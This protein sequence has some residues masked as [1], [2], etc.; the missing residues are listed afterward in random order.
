MLYLGLQY[1]KYPCLLC[2]RA[3]RVS[4]IET[5]VTRRR[6]GKRSKDISCPC[7]LKLMD[8]P[9][10]LVSKTVPA[11][12]FKFPCI[13]LR[14]NA[15]FSCSLLKEGIDIG[16]CASCPAFITYC[17]HPARPFDQIKIS[18]MP[19]AAIVSMRELLCVRN[20]VCC[21]W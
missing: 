11:G 20:K 1:P 5:T 4:P 8:A 7:P 9:S 12:S 17:I 18:C 13:D 21:L 16:T 3:G 14:F 10:R 2:G 6:A 19:T 15:F